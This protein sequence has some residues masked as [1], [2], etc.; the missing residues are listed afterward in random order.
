MDSG[1][2]V[3][4]RVPLPRKNEGGGGA[5]ATRLQTMRQWHLIFSPF[6]APLYLRTPS[7]ALYKSS[8]II[9]SDRKSSQAS[10]TQYCVYGVVIHRSLPSL[11]E[12]LLYLALSNGSLFPAICRRAITQHVSQSPCDSLVMG[13][14]RSLTD[15]RGAIIYSRWQHGSRSM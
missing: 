11:T 10:Q 8:I 15:N 4:T 7:M 9:I 5:V 14:L 12:V 2:I 6:T 1:K 13:R 3:G